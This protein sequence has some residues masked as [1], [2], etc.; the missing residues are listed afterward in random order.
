MWAFLFAECCR[1]RRVSSSNPEGMTDIVAPISN[2]G[3]FPSVLQT[4]PLKR[5]AM[6]IYLFI[7]SRDARFCVSTIRKLFTSQIRISSR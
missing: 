4:A 7:F 3:E 1:S 5:A 2:G 6:I